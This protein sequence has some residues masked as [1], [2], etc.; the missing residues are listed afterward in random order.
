MELEIP[1]TES[2]ENEMTVQGEFASESTME[3]WG[4]SKFL[5]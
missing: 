4:W 5:D 2:L 1:Q 3:S